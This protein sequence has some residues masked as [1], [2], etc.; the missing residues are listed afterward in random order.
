MTNLTV[1]LIV[2][3]LFGALMTLPFI[4]LELVNR[5]NYSEDFPTGLF[6]LLWLLSAAFSLILFPIIRDARAGNKILARP[7]WLLVRVIALGVMAWLWG[8]TILDQM[9]CFLGVP[10]CD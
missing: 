8:G 1:T 2:S 3:A 9:P 7:G 5:R 4:T 6:V 10:N